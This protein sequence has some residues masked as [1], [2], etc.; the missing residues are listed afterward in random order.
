MCPSLPERDPLQGSRQIH[1]TASFQKRGEIVLP[2]RFVKIGG[3]EETGFIQMTSSARSITETL[4]AHEH[5]TVLE[6]AFE[7][8]GDFA[9]RG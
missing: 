5:A 9:V 1:L 7:D 4:H 2:R 3:E 8:S 6:G